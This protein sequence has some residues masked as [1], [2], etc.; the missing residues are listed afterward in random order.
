MSCTAGRDASPDGSRP[1]AACRRCEGVLR[2]RCAG[3]LSFAGR[4]RRG[5]G[6]AGRR[7]GSRRRTAAVLKRGTDATPGTWPA[8]E[9]MRPN[10]ALLT[11]ADG[12]H[13]DV[14]P[15]EGAEPPFD[16]GRPL[17]GACRVLGGEP[18]GGL[19]GPKHVDSAKARLGVDSRMVAFVDQALVA[20]RPSEVL[21][22]PVP[23]NDLAHLVPQERVRCW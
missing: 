23:G 5:R 14:G 4:G 1:E 8:H 21:D 11:M 10:P 13:P 17:A 9:R 16:V 7:A 6:C 2:R 19:A 15:L 20:D 22:H 18:H 12:T 3:M